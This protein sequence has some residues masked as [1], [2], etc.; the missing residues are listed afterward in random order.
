MKAAEK[1]TLTFS[2]EKCVFPVN[3]IDLL[4]Y[5]ISHNFIKSD[6][7]CLAPLLNLPVLEESKSL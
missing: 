2:E 1:E 5:R 6:P 4:G 7:D 3:T